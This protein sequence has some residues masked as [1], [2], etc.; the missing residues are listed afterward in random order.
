[1]MHISNVVKMRR[2]RRK[3]SRHEPRRIMKNGHQSSLSSDTILLLQEEENW[4]KIFSII[5]EYSYI[6]GAVYK[7]T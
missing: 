7:Y 3:Y 1:M 4:E 5:L 6:H 2:K